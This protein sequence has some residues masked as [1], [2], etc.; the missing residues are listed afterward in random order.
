MFSFCDE[1][2]TSSN[3]AYKIYRQVYNILNN[4]PFKVVEPGFNK[5]LCTS[6]SG[7]FD[8]RCANKIKIAAIIYNNFDMQFI[9][10]IEKCDVNNKVEIYPTSLDNLDV[11]VNLNNP[12]FIGL[13]SQIPVVYPYTISRLFKY[14]IPLLCLDGINSIVPKSLGGC[15]ILPSDAKGAYIRICKISENKIRYNVAQNE[16]AN[17]EF[18]SIN[19]STDNTIEVYR[20][21]LNFNVLYV[22]HDGGGGVLYAMYDIIHNLPSNFNVYILRGGIDKFRLYKYRS[23][24]DYELSS[25][26]RSIYHNFKLISEWNIKHKY[27]IKSESIRQYRQIYRH[28][29][30]EYH[31]DVVHIHHLIKHTFDIAH[32]AHDMNIKTILSIHD[33]YY[34]CP[35][36]NLFDDKGQYCGGRCSPIMT[37]D[38]IK[39]QC[40]VP[41]NIRPPLLKEFIA[42]WREQVRDMFSCISEIIVPSQFVYNLYTNFYPEIKQKLHI[43]EHGYDSSSYEIT[44]ADNLKTRP[45]RILI[46]GNIGYHKGAWFITKLKELD[47]DGN[48]ELHFI[49][50]LSREYELEKV[51]IYHGE[52]E[53]GDFNKFV[54]EIKPHF[55]GI[56]SICAETYCYT[57]TEAWSSKTPVVALDMGAVGE[58]IRTNGGGY[59]LSNDP[60]VAYRE[61]IELSGDVKSYLDMKDEI[62]DI[63]ITSTSDIT[64]EYVDLYMK[65]IK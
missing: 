13:F 38:P 48:I 62:E 55:I 44:P 6:S 39:G 58:R 31:I 51:G 22:L 37:N 8:I 40:Y 57:L 25:D 15:F 41:K 50:K 16:I 7:M 42:Q 65:N 4:K 29:L 1:F 47:V 52:Y 30:F 64:G 45:I 5:V 35:S 3:Y 46:P 54:D 61:I 28:I 18:N 26:D 34:V 32:I 53:R 43:I 14:S 60:N 12:H 10:E 9:H 2:I 56:F 36:Y 49:G 27:T 19:N 23:G 24:S 59:L 33:F 20:N 21:N 11:T 17:I 63:K